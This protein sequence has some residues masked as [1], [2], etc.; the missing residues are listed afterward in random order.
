[1]QIASADTASVMISLFMVV[2]L[3]DNKNAI[4]AKILHAI[5]TSQEARKMVVVPRIL[6]KYCT[7][8]HLPH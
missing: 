5:A 4:V 2:F 3:S 8:P 1:V 7:N 6:R